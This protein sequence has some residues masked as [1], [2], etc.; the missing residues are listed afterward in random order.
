MTFGGKTDVPV[1]DHDACKKFAWKVAGPRA[2][3]HIFHKQPGLTIRPPLS[4]QLE[5][6]A[7]CLRAVPQFIRQHPRNDSATDEIVVPAW[8]GPLTLTLSWVPA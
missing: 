2:Y 3:P 5:L 7:G 6:M 1:A 4:W 8:W